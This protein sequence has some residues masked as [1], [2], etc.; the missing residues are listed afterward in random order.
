MTFPGSVSS[1]CQTCSP[2]NRWGMTA[3]AVFLSGVMLVIFDFDRPGDGFIRVSQTSL[4]DVIAA[5]EADLA[6]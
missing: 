3:L 5:M 6:K 1:G 4:I 2:Q